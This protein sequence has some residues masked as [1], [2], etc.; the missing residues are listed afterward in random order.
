MKAK[1]QGWLV[2]G[3]EALSLDERWQKLAATITSRHRSCERRL[4]FADDDWSEIAC[5]ILTSSFFARHR[6]AV[7]KRSEVWFGGDYHFGSPGHNKGAPVQEVEAVMRHLPFDVSIIFVCE[8]KKL[9]TTKLLLALCQTLTVS[10]VAGI[11][12]IQVARMAKTY[13]TEH[14]I[15]CSPVLVTKLIAT[16]PLN[17][18]VIKHELSKLAN[19][20]LIWDEHVFQALNQQLVVGDEMK[21][22]DY[23]LMQN[24]DAFFKLSNALSY[25]RFNFMFFCRLLEKSM[26]TYRN[27]LCLQA[28]G[29]Y[30][31]AVAAQKLKVNVFY[32]TIL[33]KNVY[34][35]QYDH[36]NKILIFLSSLI[37]TYLRSGSGDFNFFALNLIKL[38]RVAAFLQ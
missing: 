36:V 10:K 23:F 37:T 4:F 1:Q 29:Y 31:P 26:V 34:R 3:P 38:T 30:P 21:L 33:L 13:I 11:T 20:S 14:G 8:S 12:R 17:R 27:Y 5:F 16:L 32:L 6:I 19:L 15:S 24:W 2:Y 25:Q 18:Y 22:H 7:I 9:K 35:Y 28:E